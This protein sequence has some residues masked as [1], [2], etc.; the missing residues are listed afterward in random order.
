MAD[1]DLIRRG[2]A[3]AV[4]LL[5]GSPVGMSERLN[6]LPAQGME[7]NRE[8]MLWN[9]LE[10]IDAQIY[11]AEEISPEFA[12]RVNDALWDNA[13]LAAMKELK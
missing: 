5:G 9:L 7:T 12:E 11:L 13:A 4:V 6:A 1:D 8:T 3:H 10:E 2:D